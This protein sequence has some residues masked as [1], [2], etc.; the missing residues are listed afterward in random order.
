MPDSAVPASMYFRGLGTATPPARY[1]KEDCL[2]AFQNSAW[3]ARLDARAHFVAR[4]VL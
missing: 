2:E 1:T 3:F 4:T